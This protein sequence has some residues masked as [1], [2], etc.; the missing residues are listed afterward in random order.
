MGVA[1][2]GQVASAWDRI[3]APAVNPFGRF[4]DGLQIPLDAV[5]PDHR[6]APLSNFF[7]GVERI[8][9]DPWTPG[10]WSF[11]AQRFLEE[12]RLG[13]ASRVASSDPHV[14]ELGAYA[15]TAFH[16]APAALLARARERHVRLDLPRRTRV[17]INDSLPP[18]LDAVDLA[19]RLAKDGGPAG[20]ANAVLEFTGDAF[21]TLPFHARRRLLA[22][23]AATGCLTAVAPL[24]ASAR[25]GW[26]QTANRPALPLGPAQEPEPD[27]RHDELAIVNASMIEA[28][29]LV[30]AGAAIRPAH[31][32]PGNDLDSVVVGGCVGGD[33][34]S[35]RAFLIRLEQAPIAEGVTVR[36]VPA[37]ARVQEAAQRTGLTERAERAGAAF[38]A[39]LDLPLQ[40]GLF[41]STTPCLAPRGLVA[42]LATCAASAH[43]GRVTDPEAHP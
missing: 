1:G 33:L 13:A 23:T 9:A 35:L 24:D 25:D 39:P 5:L 32:F 8:R 15:V 11:P 30:P 22:A 18:D 4:E 14:T 40:S 6:C 43:A 20:F 12:S 17:Q 28:L 42:S 34:D 10:G 3:A 27:R 2:M 31:A 7:D 36:L 41:L 21:G 38:A 26:S 29:V 37:S 16:H 19:L